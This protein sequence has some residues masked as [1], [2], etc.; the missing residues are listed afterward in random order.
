MIHVRCPHCDKTLK[1]LDQYAGK[2]ARCPNCEQPITVPAPPKPGQ[3]EATPGAHGAEDPPAASQPP[4]ENH[5]PNRGPAVAAPSRGVGSAQGHVARPGIQ[6]DGI[7][8]S[9]PEPIASK[10]EIAAPQTP[11]QAGGAEWLARHR[12]KPA[13]PSEGRKLRPRFLYWLFALA[14]IPLAWSLLGA[15]N[16]VEERFLRT[17]EANPEVFAKIETE[18]EMSKEKLFSLLP[19]GRIDGAMLPQDTWTHWWYALAAAATFAV[20]FF[21]LFDAGNAEFRHVLLIGLCT[22]TFGILFLT[23]VQWLA[24]ATQGHLFWGRS[25]LVLLLYIL[26]FIG[27]L[28]RS[29]LDPDAG[30][31]VSLLGFTFGVGLCEELTKALPI[32]FH[33]RSG[34]RLDWRGARLWGLASGAGF[35]VAE[36][37]MYSS[38]SYNGIQTAGVYLVRFVS[39]AAMHAV[40]GAAVGIA[41]WRRREWIAQQWDWKDF[42]VTLL[43]VLAVPMF[44]HGLYDTLL[45]KDLYGWALVA[46][47]ASFAWLAVLTEWTEVEEGPSYDA[48]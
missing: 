12:P 41:V 19:D 33:Y 16:D 38:Q 36:G 5:E 27:F 10:T 43:W 7:P 30:F 44:L 37:I 21:L 13:V 28:Y 29:A 32:L 42:V 15:R 8:V 31:A 2:T 18:K 39:C 26:E 1:A 3:S 24:E 45:K 22:A 35:G 9:V 14:L 11:R 40:W 23:C 4:A 25:I 6:P 46:A 47:L 20:V 34:G 48:Q 17:I